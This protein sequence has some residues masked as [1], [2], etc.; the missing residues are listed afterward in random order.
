MHEATSVIGRRREAWRGRKSEGKIQIKNEDKEE[1]EHG[2]RRKKRGN[3][4]T[5]EHKDLR[6]GKK[7]R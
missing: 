7:M 4:T 6:E 1:T 5:K 3:M 2:R